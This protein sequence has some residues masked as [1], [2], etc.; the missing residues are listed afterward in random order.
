MKTDYYEILGVAKN[1]SKDDIKKAYR[2]LAKKYH[3]DVNHGNKE[4]EEKF[5]QISNAYEILS[6]DNKRQKYDNP[7]NNEHVAWEQHYGGGF[8]NIDDMINDF[9]GRSFT[10]GRRRGEG[11][12]Q[13]RVVKGEDL[14]IT[15]NVDLKEVSNGVNKNIRLIKD[16][17][18]NDCNGNGTDGGNSFDAC[19]QC[20]GSGKI[21]IQHQTP[22]GHIR[23]SMAC[24][25]CGGYGK[26]VKNK[27]KKCNGNGV[28]SHEET[29]SVNIPA[30]ISNDMVFYLKNKGGYPKKCTGIGINGDLIVVI[31]EKK[32]LNFIRDGVNVMCDLHINFAD[33]ILGKN[34]I[35][36]TDH[37][38]KIHKITI[39]KFSKNGDCVK[40][41]NGGIPQFENNGIIG[42]F[43]I[44]FNIFIPDNISL[45]SEKMLEKLSKNSDFIYK[46]D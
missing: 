11:R 12:T 3:P 35:S 41:K 30:G 6:D 13:Q 28:N 4:Y 40:I 23:N 42:D 2:D 8:S 16:V 22:F 5:K 39:K 34:D 24:N 9:M 29:L 15:I 25:H 10:G 26:I 1:A 21:T 32:S 7:V 14:R 33:M 27:C 31:K 38:D 37:V 46:K 19:I 36:V 18:C 43:I 44:R 20:G 17:M 45:D